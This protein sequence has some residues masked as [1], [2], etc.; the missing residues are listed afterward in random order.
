M[1]RAVELIDSDRDLHRFVWRS[2]EDEPLKDYRMTR[3]TFGVSASSFAA[4][5]SVKRN[6][7]DHALE[8]PKA[9]NAVESAFYVDDCLMGVDSID[10]AIGLHHQLLNLLAKG[11]FLL[12]KWSSSDPAVLHHIS[13]ELRDTQSTHHIPSPDG[14]TKTLGIEW[15]ANLDLTV[16]S[17]Q[18]TDNVTKRALIS[19]I[20]KTFDALG[21]F[22]PTI[23]KAKILLQRLWES[24]IGW[25][26][27][28]PPAIY[29]S[30]L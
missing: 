17:L 4:N 5:T 7:L 14:Y 22:S 6:A 10:E 11:G 9:A 25:D 21:W 8:F 16:A 30:W 15:N 23:I 19:D 3:V 27:L 18:D 20:A 28:L 13:P 2:N 24:R 12:R 29:Q 1:Y 26:D